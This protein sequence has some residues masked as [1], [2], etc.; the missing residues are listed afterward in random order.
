MPIYL[1]Y[2]GVPGTVRRKGKMW[3]ELEAAQLGVNRTPAGGAAAGNPGSQRQPSEVVIT[4]ASDAASTALYRAS[5]SGAPAKAVVEFVNKDRN[6]AEEAPYLTLELEGVLI[7]S[8]STSGSGG[9]GGTPTETLTLNYQRV[10]YSTK[11]PGKA[12]DRAQ[13]V[14][15]AE[16]FL[17]TAKGA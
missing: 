9:T 5:L 12:T 14:D 2:E 4:K 7:S 3:I 6:G 16:W 13:R 1:W 8:Y 11:A 17:G 10:K 15:R